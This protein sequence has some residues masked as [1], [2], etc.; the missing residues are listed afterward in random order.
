M[1][2]AIVWL[3]GSNGESVMDLIV[4]CPLPLFLVIVLAIAGF[5]GVLAWNWY[6]DCLVNLQLR[7]EREAFLEEREV[8]KKVL[9][10]READ[11]ERLCQANDNIFR[12]LQEARDTL[13]KQTDVISKGQN[14]I[15]SL[16]QDVERLQTERSSLLAEAEKAVVDIGQLTSENVKLKE[17]LA[18]NSGKKKKGLW[19]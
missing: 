8:S 10:Q 3:L 19:K 2:V 1:T 17:E 4:Y 16:V 13:A 18:L 5:L 9:T 11:N 6:C 14:R 12:E 7:K 15:V